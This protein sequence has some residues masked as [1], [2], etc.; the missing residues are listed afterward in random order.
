[1]AENTP[2]TIGSYVGFATVNPSGILQTGPQNAGNYNNVIQI[3]SSSW[4]ASDGDANFRV[5]VIMTPAPTNTSSSEAA[6]YGHYSSSSPIE[7]N[8]TGATF[9]YY[10]QSYYVQSVGKYTNDGGETQYWIA[11]STGGYY[12]C[13]GNLYTYHI[14]NGDVPTSNVGAF[15]F[16]FYAPNGGLPGQCV[17]PCTGGQT[18]NSSSGV[19]YTV[20]VCEPPCNTAEGWVCGSSN[21]CTVSGS[22]ICP[23]GCAAGSTC[24][25]GNTG[26][27]GGVGSTCQLLLPCGGCP[28]G[29][30]CDNGACVSQQHR[31]HDWWI[32]VA[33]AAVAIVFFFVLVVVIVLVTRKKKKHPEEASG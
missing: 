17:P 12:C 13:G 26:V 7:G 18:C 31:H 9:V 16:V 20:G 15:S 22:P 8:N 29:Q 1:M 10:G 19:C 2:I 3:Q 24:V 4:G 21:V 6:A 30:T 25:Y 14:Q 32:W 23:A 27:A 5:W 11:G 33:I 28:T